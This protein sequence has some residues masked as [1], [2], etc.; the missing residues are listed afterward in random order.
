MI[1]YINCYGELMIKDYSGKDI[2][3]INTYNNW[4]KWGYNQYGELISYEDYA[5]NKE[6]Y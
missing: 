3:G 6:N 5:G 4:I 2:F 1:Y